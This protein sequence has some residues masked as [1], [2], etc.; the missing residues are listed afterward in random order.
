MEVRITASAPG[1]LMLF[2]EHAVVYGYPCIVTAVD[3]RMRAS[4]GFNGKGKIAVSAPEVGLNEYQKKISSLGKDRIPKP[5]RF[6][7]VLVKNFKN[8]FGLGGGLD[9][10]T[11]CDFSADYGF[12][13]SAAVT[14]SLAYGLAKLHRLKTTKKELFE[15]CY[16]TVI[17]VQ[18]V[19]SGFDIAAAIYGGTLYYIKG[20]KKIEPL[21][22]DKRLSI[23]VGYT[24]VKADTPTLVRQVAEQYHHNKKEVS[25]IFIKIG[26]IVD[27]VREGVSVGDIRKFGKLMN[28]N[29]ILLH[30]LGVSSRELDK[31]IK[32]ALESGAWGA[33]LSGAGGG[34][35][36]LTLGDK[37]DKDKIEEAIEGAGGKVLE[38]GL[39]AEGVRI[40]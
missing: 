1:K 26:E 19:G 22:L 28:E 7:E 5:V 27:K 9:I 33:K 17:D 6:I 14:V 23:S 13:S 34:D 30:K 39:G 3:K 37:K 10:V 2:G 15:I 36:M 40:E 11:E 18:G 12:G 32:T 21:S 31:I 29:Q 20:G 24:G 35:C 25:E 38:V 4:V 8:N 16:K